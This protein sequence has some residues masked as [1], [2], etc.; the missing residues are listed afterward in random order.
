MGHRGCLWIGHFRFHLSLHFKARLG[1]KSLLWKSV[2]IHIE[3]RT[4][5][6]N[7]NFALRLALK[8]RPRGTRKWPIGFSNA[9]RRP[10][11]HFLLHF[12]FFK[13]V[14]RSLSRCLF[15]E[16]RLWLRGARKDE[17]IGS[18]TASKLSLLE[19]IKSERQLYCVNTLVANYQASTTLSAWIFEWKPCTEETRK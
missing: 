2:F 15:D 9:V 5:Y 10:R 6:H 4:N 13:V 18:T 3:I 12:K 11:P 1:A 8:E 16:Q 14:P 7:K 19:I 17:L